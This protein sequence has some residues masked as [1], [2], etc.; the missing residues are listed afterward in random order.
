MMMGERRSDQKVNWCKKEAWTFARKFFL[1]FKNIFRNT[2]KQFNLLY[3]YFCGKN[4]IQ[5]HD[6]YESDSQ[7]DNE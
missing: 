4:T 7:E 2:I 6:F 3:I 5:K 1:L